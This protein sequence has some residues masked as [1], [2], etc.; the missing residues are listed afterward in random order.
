[1]DSVM[2]TMN[3]HITYWPK[4]FNKIII[5]NKCINNYTKPQKHYKKNFTNNNYL[6]KLDHCF[7]TIFI[8]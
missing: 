3:D 2:W 1:M 7:S 8:S 4:L 5:H 6:I